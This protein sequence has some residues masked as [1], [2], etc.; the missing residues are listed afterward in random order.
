MTFAIP[1]F[2]GKDIMTQSAPHHQL[3]KILSYVDIRVITFPQ[4]EW[5]RCV[6]WSWCDLSVQRLSVLVPLDRMVSSWKRRFIGRNFYSVSLK[7]LPPAC[8]GFFSK[9]TNSINHEQVFDYRPLRGKLGPGENRAVHPPLLIMVN[10]VATRMVTMEMFR[11][12]KHIYATS[13]QTVFLQELA[14][15]LL[16]ISGSGGRVEFPH[17]SHQSEKNIL[18]I[19][20]WQGWCFQIG[21]F[22]FL[23]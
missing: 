20:I 4:R 8:K 18:D 16:L 13:W 9:P 12:Y 2:H 3:N 11:I 1:I 22:K 15:L 14:G 19:G 10:R 6:F 21:N 7:E 23:G 5:L 17:I